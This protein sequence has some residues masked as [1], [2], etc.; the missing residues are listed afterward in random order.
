MHSVVIKV[1]NQIAFVY[2][3]YPADEIG[4]VLYSSL[5]YNITEM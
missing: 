4:S 3:R 2:F 1:F 5:L